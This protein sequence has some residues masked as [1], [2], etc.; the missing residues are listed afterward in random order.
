VH[1]KLETSI[2]LKAEPKPQVS[3]LISA[4]VKLGIS[5]LISAQAEIKTETINL[6]CTVISPADHPRTIR[7]SSTAR[8]L[9]VLCLSAAHP[10]LVCGRAASSKKLREEL[11]EEQY[12]HAF[13][14]KP[15]TIATTAIEFNAGKA[16]VN[17]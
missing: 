2:G 16:Q 3:V 15:N 8:P 17:I 5:V 10:P 1:P 4:P 11:R 13:K 9:F 6:S 14:A 7:C 12:P